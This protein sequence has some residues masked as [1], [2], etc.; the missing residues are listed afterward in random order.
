MIISKVSSSNIKRTTHK[1]LL[2]DYLCHWYAM[3]LLLNFHA[4]KIQ[5]TYQCRIDF[6]SII[7]HHDD[8]RCSQQ[9]IKSWRRRNVEGW[10]LAGLSQATC[11]WHSSP[12]NNILLRGNKVSM[13]IEN[14]KGNAVAVTTYRVLD[15]LWLPCYISFI[16]ALKGWSH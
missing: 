14:C 8:Y 13:H 2:L 4:L 7:G 10:L 16:R 11:H 15:C 12:L 1:L 5:A 6:V 3:C 9:I